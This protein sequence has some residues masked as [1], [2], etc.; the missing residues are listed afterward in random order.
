MCCRGGFMSVYQDKINKFY[1]EIEELQA[2]IDQKEKAIA[3]YYRIIRLQE[4]IWS[5]EF[6]VTKKE[7]DL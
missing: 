5:G 6:I 4:H 1:R 3:E 2:Q 7:E